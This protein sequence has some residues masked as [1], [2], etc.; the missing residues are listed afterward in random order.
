MENW[1]APKIKGRGMVK[2]NPFKSVVEQYDEINQMITDQNKVNKPILTEDTKERIQ[3]FLQQSLT[4]NEEI[5]LSYHRNGYLHHQ[6]ITVASIDPGN[7]LIHCLDAF[8][9][10]VQP[11]YV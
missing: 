3:R 6:Y 7:E 9:T 4:C 1:G 5:F 2:W 10:G 8:N 11:R